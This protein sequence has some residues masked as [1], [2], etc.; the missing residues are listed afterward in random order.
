MIVNESIGEQMVRVSPS[1]SDLPK[2]WSWRRLNDLCE[3]I[4]DCPHSTPK[5]TATGPYVARTQDVL[6]GVFLTVSAAHVSD[7]TYYER[8]KRAVP[9]RGDL[10]YSREGTYFG[11]AAEVP[12]R[13]RVCLGQRMVL[14]RPDEAAIDFRF[15]RYWLNSPVMGAYIN[16]FR[17]GSVA[18]RLNLPTIRSLPV[19][20]PPLPEQREIASVLGALDDKIALNER[21]AVTAHE[22]GQAHSRLA[23]EGGKAMRLAEVAQITMGSSP[24]GESYNE[25]S[26]GLPFYQGTRDFGDRFPG[27]RVWCTS[28]VRTADPGSCLLSV[29]APVGRINI[30]REL[31]CIGRGVAAVQ[32]AQG[33]PAVLY[34]ELVAS[35]D[36]WVPYESEGTV[37]GAIN[38]KQLENVEILALDPESAG[39]LEGVLAPLGQRVASS[40]DENRKLAELRDTLLPKLMS[41]EIR[42]GDAEKAAEDV[43]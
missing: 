2:T 38:K 26:I 27:R 8:T 36:A 1:V 29:R 30:A 11:N 9:K 24:P 18:E 12:S 43:T 17:D 33:T 25:D 5:L 4:Y 22:L 28:P 42:V 3:G 7:D 31:C 16:G 41:G 6:T 34:Y 14:I 21:V 20:I 32:S 40:F 10:L 13:I 15:L 37:F 19:L 35:S 39:D 23:H